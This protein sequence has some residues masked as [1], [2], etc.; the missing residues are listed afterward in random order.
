MRKAALYILLASTAYALMGMCVKLGGEGISN[1]E[2]VFMRNA[3]CLITLLPF[4]VFSKKCSLKTSFLKM[5]SLRSIAGLLNM[6]CFFF[7]IHYILLSD[8][9]L[10]NNTMPLFVPFILWVWKGK[11]ISWTLLPGLLLGF[12]GVA[13]ILQPGRSFFHPAALLALASGFFMSISMTEMS[14]LNKKEPIFRILFYYFVISTALS[15]LPLIWAWKTPTNVQWEIFLAVGLF[16]AI[17]Q[18]FLTKGYQHVAADKISPLIYFAVVVSGVFDW[19]FWGQR[20]DIVSFIGI[21]CVFIG[22][23]LCIRKQAR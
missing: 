13:L 10:L 7:S 1:L 12:L 23:I 20:P 2:L 19:V 21:A 14:E 17:Y 6:Y 22:A 11:K 18:Y 4:V 3:I 9:M 5:H 16:A 15:A 8:A